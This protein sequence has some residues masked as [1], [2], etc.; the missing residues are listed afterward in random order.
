MR[1]AALAAL[2]DVVVGRLQLDASRII[3]CWADQYAAGSTLSLPCDIGTPEAPL[4]PGSQRV[5]EYDDADAE[6]GDQD[7]A[8]AGG[9][10]FGTQSCPHACA[11]SARKN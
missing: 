1:Y 4:R 8:H 11:R 7:A 6:D 3:V 2:Q 5:S 10:T 9:K